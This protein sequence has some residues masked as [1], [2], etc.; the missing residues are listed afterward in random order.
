MKIEEQ[1]ILI[2]GGAGS[3][4]SFLVSDLC[5]TARK[6]IVIDKNIEKLEELKEEFQ[7]IDIF[8]CDLT[9]PDQL[10]DTVTAIYRK[11]PVS[12]LINNAGFIHSEPLINIM[13]PENRKH[14]FASWDET[15]KA[16]LYTTFYM[17]ASVAEQMVINKIKGLIISMSSIA[18][19]GNIGQTA[20]A[21][22]KAGIE[23]MTVTWTKELGIFGIR[24]SAIAPGFFD[25]VS[26]Q[27]ALS[28]NNIKKWTKAVP[29]NRFGSLA[30]LSSAV[31]FIIENDYY[32]GQV[33]E[34]NGGLV[35]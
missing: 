4:G 11:Y 22:S 1:I 3:I 35:I 31:K 6:I 29:L 14:S 21:A 19:K 34:L 18:A 2:T 30:E 5:K 13:K 33:L 26:T 32:N 20:Y 15:I 27:N 17:T 8:P 7:D 9:N 16:N 10:V 25:T 24:A 12:V 28:E 23:A